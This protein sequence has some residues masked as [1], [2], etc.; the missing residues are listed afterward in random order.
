MCG[1][2]TNVSDTLLDSVFTSLIGGK[3]IR[4]RNGGWGIFLLEKQTLVRKINIQW[5]D[6]NVDSPFLFAV[7]FHV[8][9]TAEELL[10]STPLGVVMFALSSG[11]IFNPLPAVLPPFA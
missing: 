3:P 11:S 8:V 9:D 6:N 10:P 7:E 5:D 2:S 1:R 4:L